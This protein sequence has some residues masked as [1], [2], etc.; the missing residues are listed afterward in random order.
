M[1]T[2][3]VALGLLCVLGAACFARGVVLLARVSSPTGSVIHP[4]TA[5]DMFVCV[6]LFILL[7]TGGV[8]LLVGARRA[9]GDSSRD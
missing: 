9:G 6:L 7:G 3:R 1:R 5:T 8:V 4:E 2:I